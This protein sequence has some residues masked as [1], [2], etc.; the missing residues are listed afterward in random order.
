MATRRV[1]ANSDIIRALFDKSRKEIVNSST[2]G[3]DFLGNALSN[4]LVDIIYEGRRLKWCNDLDSLKAFVAEVLDLNGKWC[5]PGGGSKRFTSSNAELTLT[6]YS[7][8]Q[9]TLLFQGKDGNLIRDGCVKFCQ[10]RDG[11]TK[12]SCKQCKPCRKIQCYSG[13]SCIA[14][15]ILESDQSLQ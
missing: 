8:K 2:I 12:S 11:V 9:N 6:W 4:G 13:I 5:S 14:Q 3:T 10:T 1:M 15:N 7:G